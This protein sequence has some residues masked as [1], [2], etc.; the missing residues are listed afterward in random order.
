MV[1]YRKVYRFTDRRNEVAASNR[2]SSSEASTSCG[3]LVK[4]RV[5]QRFHLPA[6][7]TDHVR[8]AMSEAGDRGATAH[9]QV[10]PALTIVDGYAA[11]GYR[12]QTASLRRAVKNRDGSL[13]STSKSS[14]AI[15]MS[16]LAWPVCYLSA[17]KSPSQSTFNHLSINVQSQ[18]NRLTV[19]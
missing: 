15:L 2:S 17:N 1:Q 13:C 5:R 16:S 14:A 12:Q 19:A 3:S 18:A 10:L 7:R 4:K 8:V 6:D 9:V 11:R